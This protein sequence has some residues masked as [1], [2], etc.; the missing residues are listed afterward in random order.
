M[1]ADSAAAGGQPRM[2]T[3]RIDVDKMAEGL[4]LPITN[5]SGHHDQNGNG[6]KQALE[7]ESLG[8]WVVP[9]YAAGE[10]IKSK[11][12][13]AKG[14]EPF[15]PK[16][17]LTRRSAV[18]LIDHFQKFPGQGI[19]ICFGPGKGPTQAHFDL[20]GEPVDFH[21]WLIDLEGDGERADNSLL[22]LLGPSPPATMGWLAT[23]GGHNTFTADGGRLLSL[24]AAAG[25][26]E[27]TGLKAGVWKVPELPDLEFRIG[28]CKSDGTVKQCQSVVPPTPG[29]DGKPREWI[30]PP[31]CGVAALPETA[32]A[33]LEIL[34][35]TKR[36]GLDP[37]D[38]L[39]MAYFKSTTPANSV[40]SYAQ[41][42]LAGECSEVE[43][44]QEGNRNNRLN[45][46]ALKLGGLVAAGAL[47]RSDVE[48]AL[49]EAARRC[50]L[51]NGEVAATIKSGLDDGIKKPRDLSD[52]GT[53]RN[54]PPS[55]NGTGHHPSPGGDVYES[56][57]DP[58]RLAPIQLA[59]FQ[60][61]GG[62]TL[63]FYRGEW[64]EWSDGAFRSIADPELQSGVAGTIKSEFDRINRIALE[65]W[66]KANANA[67]G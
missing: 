57:D 14:K 66:E 50:G 11:N 49:T 6:V 51:G 23:R 47:V 29:T 32:Y 8:F 21:D 48:R 63:R 30:N 19:G 5:G 28:G 15:G 7:L 56:A 42:A 41:A 60:G 35:T 4:G 64:L 45:N 18:W 1:A 22:N 24:L 20:D 61:Q 52:V 2:T 9:L 65:L 31:S 12:E 55:S 58:H 44:T 3:R 34:A 53:R 10:L 38:P 62:F 39:T 33:Y 13:L 37:A 40:D 46:A 25:A 16:W 67:Q 54:G 36:Q 43:S 59:K 17:G 26:K 27:E